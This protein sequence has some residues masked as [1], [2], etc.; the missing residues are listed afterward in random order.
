RVPLPDGDGR[1][2][3][4]DGIHVRL[5]DA[6]QEL[7]RVG[8]ERFDVAPLAFGVYGVARQRAFAGAAHSGHYRQRV[9]GN[10]EADVLQVVDAR[11]PHLDGLGCGPAGGG[12]LRVS[13]RALCDPSIAVAKRIIIRLPARRANPL[14]LARL[15]PG[16]KAPATIENHHLPHWFKMHRWKVGARI[17]LK[18]STL[19]IPPATSPFGNAL[20]PHSLVV[21]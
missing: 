9:V 21:R 10:V 6:L 7:P 4:G 2:D 3:S 18:I 15:P 12:S 16:R 8:G 13:Q 1:R 14:L 19:Q 11:A 5:L 20:A 17:A